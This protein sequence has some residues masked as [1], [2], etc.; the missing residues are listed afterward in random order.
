MWCLCLVFVIISINNQ[1]NSQCLFSAENN[2]DHERVP[3][4]S[5]SAVPDVDGLHVQV[6]LGARAIRPWP[7]V[8]DWRE[9]PPSGH[10]SARLAQRHHSHHWRR[11]EEILPQRRQ[12]LCFPGI[13]SKTCSSFSCFVLLLKGLA[14]GSYLVEVDNPE[15]VYEDIRI[16]IN[17]KGKHRARKNNPV[18]PNQVI[19]S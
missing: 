13:I 19:L 12:L 5:Q 3:G 10:S 14:P 1:Y 15:Y 11:R 9:D 7:G 17:F 4:P 2:Q 16:D 6:W 8:Q 18:Q